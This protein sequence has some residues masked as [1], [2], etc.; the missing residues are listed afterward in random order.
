MSKRS[1]EARSRRRSVYRTRKGMRVP[2]VWEKALEVRREG[3]QSLGDEV[4]WFSESQSVGGA[5]E[6]YYQY[7]VRR[8]VKNVSDTLNKI[9]DGT[10]MPE[11]CSFQNPPSAHGKLN[12]AKISLA[13]AVERVTRE[14]DSKTTRIREWLDL[15]RDRQQKSPF[16]KEVMLLIRKEACELRTLWAE[17]LHVQVQIDGSGES[18]IQP[19][20][21]KAMLLAT[22]DDPGK[23][24]SNILDQCVYGVN[25]GIE[26]MEE[27]GIW[28]S[29]AAKNKYGGY[30]LHPSDRRSFNYSSAM[31]LES[32]VFDEISRQVKKGFMAEVTSEHHLKS[33]TIYICRMAAIQKRPTADNGRR[34][35]RLLDDHRRSGVNERLKCPETLCLPG[36]KSVAAAL[37]LAQTEGRLPAVPG[38]QNLPNSGSKEVWWLETDASEAFRHIPIKDD[39]K[40]YLAVRCK[41]RLF[42]HERL[43]FGLK[44]APYIWVRFMSCVEKV[45]RRIVG[46]RYSL[47]YIDDRGIPIVGGPQEAWATMLSVLLLDTIFG[48]NNSVEKI[49]L[50]QSPKTLGF[51]L[52]TETGVFRVPEEKASSLRESLEGLRNLTEVTL[53]EI[54]CLT[55]KLSWLTQVFC[56]VKLNLE[57][58][59]ALKAA[60]VKAQKK[61]Y[62]GKLPV[63]GKLRE[64]VDIWLELLSNKL[65]MSAMELLGATEVE[66]V[67]VTD[68]S[69]KG[70]GGLIIKGTKP[71][72]FFSEEINPEACKDYGIDFPPTSRD[73]CLLELLAALEALMIPG[74]TGSQMVL[75]SDNA[76]T[77]AAVSRGRARGSAKMRSLMEKYPPSCIRSFHLAGT[78]NVLADTL[79]RGGVGAT[80]LMDELTDLGAERV[81]I[82]QQ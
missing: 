43:C 44:T 69:I 66:Y 22:S 70:L 35:L 57:P 42:V 3:E 67:C 76:A 68:A 19:M 80:K 59:Y 15:D 78:K 11:Y 79:S 48:V 14:T 9:S 6:E 8:A 63:G 18:C 72:K 16:M 46:Y 52:N 77:I 29:A 4:N 40:R 71:I 73:I 53:E 50:S 65:Q 61:G 38:D 39:H 5:C 23:E 51:R 13:R 34:S 58:F 41:G 2:T 45:A 37:I 56:N 81:R 64:S 27:T 25:I 74:M 75:L 12:E 54:D 17:Q 32:E 28:P 30:E 10:S 21:L 55:G 49:C 33:E 7:A 1:A 82:M 47:I 31:A 26:P 60:F 36:I 20:L 62:R 24:D